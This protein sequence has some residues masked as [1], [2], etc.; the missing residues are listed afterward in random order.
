MPKP[1]EYVRSRAQAYHEQAH[2]MLLALVKL[3][4]AILM[5]LL[6]VQLFGQSFGF[7]LSPLAYACVPLPIMFGWREVAKLRD[8]ARRNEQGATGE[9]AIAAILEPLKHQGWQIEY[10]SYI[11]KLGDVDAFLLSPNGRGYVVEVKSHAGLVQSNG[12]YLFHTPEN[13]R[14]RPF[15]KNFLHQARQQAI[16]IKQIKNLGYV[17]PI[18]AFSHAVV[19][20]KTQPVTN[21]YVV[22]Q[23][24]L[25]GYLQYLDNKSRYDAKKKP[26]KRTDKS[27]RPKVQKPSR[28]PSP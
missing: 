28:R 2:Q 19:D 18:V 20:I 23:N 17:T 9:E 16:A 22:G 13:K 14:R 24:K 11:A 12:N 8:R 1:G 25:V 7:G 27:D 5:V 10:G 4:A 6:L 15:Q 21:V 3:S 26:I